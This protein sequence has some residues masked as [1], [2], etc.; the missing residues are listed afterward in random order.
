MAAMSA[1]GLTKTIQ[2]YRQALYPETVNKYDTMW[3]F[4]EPCEANRLILFEKERK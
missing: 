4:S 1:I 2:L 3:S